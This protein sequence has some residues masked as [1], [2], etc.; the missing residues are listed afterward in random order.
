M[1][2]DTLAL[3]HVSA[4]ACLGLGFQ[5]TPWSSLTGPLS[6]HPA[7]VSPWQYLILKARHHL[8]QGTDFVAMCTSCAPGRSKWSGRARRRAPCLP[9][10]CHLVSLLFV[11]HQNHLRAAQCPVPLGAS[12]VFVCVVQHNVAL[13]VEAHKV[14]DNMSPVL[15]AYADLA[16]E[17]LS[18]CLH[19]RSPTILYPC[20]R[21]RHPELNTTSISSSLTRAPS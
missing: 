6:A 8:V 3:T 1:T 16:G 18:R 2:E 5:R 9:Q 7:A 19:V 12:L 15:A 14:S 10:E 11:R 4:T 13:R 17:Q 20:A 21:R